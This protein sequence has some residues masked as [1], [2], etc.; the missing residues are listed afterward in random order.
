MDVFARETRKR[1]SR[2]YNGTTV[3]HVGDR[4]LKRGCVCVTG[5]RR[6]QFMEHFYR[7]MCAVRKS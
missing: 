3:A 4:R 7:S 1:E 5:D 6:C 2:E